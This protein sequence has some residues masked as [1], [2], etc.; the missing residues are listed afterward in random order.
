MEK[1]KKI[2]LPLIAIVFLVSTFLNIKNQYITLQKARL[3]NE[4]LKVTIEK[5]KIKKQQLIKKIEYASSSAYI[6]QQKREL[7]ALGTETDMWL[8][9]PKKEDK[10]E[11]KPEINEAKIE[12]NWEKW[13]KL[14]T[15]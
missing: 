15:Q 10:T 9:L 13:T 8:D 5:M 11:Y 1:I 2:T 7:L 6:D 12:T 14:F 4:E 3:K